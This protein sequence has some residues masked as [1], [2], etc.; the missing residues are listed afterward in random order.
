VVELDAVLPC[1]VL[2][3]EIGV[4]EAVWDGGRFIAFRSFLII[5]IGYVFDGCFVQ[6]LGLV[7]GWAVQ[8]IDRAAL[9]RGPVVP[10]EHQVFLI[11]IAL[12]GIRHDFSGIGAC[13]LHAVDSFSPQSVR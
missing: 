2:L 11:L 4:D 6:K 7:S 5:V 10:Y 9:T 3:E 13:E 8:P 12:S 1:T